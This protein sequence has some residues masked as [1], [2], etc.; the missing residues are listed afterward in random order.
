MN[1]KIESGH[2]IPPPNSKRSYH[3]DYPFEKMEIG[4][5]FFVPMLPEHFSVRSGNRKSMAWV[6][7]EHIRC[8]ARRYRANVNEEFK[9]VI[10]ERHEDLHGEEGLRVWRVE[11]KDINKE[12][13]L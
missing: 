7:Q 4:S 5:E 1:Y 8:Q 11:R 6:K 12:G 3:F 10:R 2:K 9:I 13:E